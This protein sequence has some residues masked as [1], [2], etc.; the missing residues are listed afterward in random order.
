MKKTIEIRTDIFLT[1]IE[2]SEAITAWLGSAN[3]NLPNNA[4]FQWDATEE[5]TLKHLHITYRENEE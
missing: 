4:C 3:I 2:V 1:E 5:G